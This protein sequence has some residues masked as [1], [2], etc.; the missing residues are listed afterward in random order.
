MTS[1]EKLEINAALRF[2]IRMEVGSLAE[3][4]EVQA[5][6]VGVETVNPTLG[7]SV[8][9]A[10]IG[11][12]PLNGRNVLD[13]ALLQ[14]GVTPTS[15][16]SCGACTFSVAGSKGDSVTFLLDGGINNNLLDNSVVFNPNPDTIEEFRILTSNYTAE[17][18]RNSGGIVSTV[19]KSGTN[20]LHGS[21]FE[22][23]R[24][25]AFNANTYFN[26]EQGIDRPV[27][28]R[29]QFG[30]SLGGP[31]VIPKVINGKDR[32]FWFFGWQSQRQ[33]SMVQN[34][35]VA[36][37]T[38]SELA[39]N[40]SQ[41]NSDRTGPDPNVVDFLQRNPYYQPN[42]GLAAQGII[43]PSRISSVL[44]NYIKAG[45]IPTSPTGILF[46]QGSETRNYNEYLGKTRYS[47][48]AER[49]HFYPAG[50]PRPSD[51]QSL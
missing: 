5:E 38:P 1:P 36:T 39:G 37:Y 2:D 46:P 28:K 27:L 51:D 25:D 33:T 18:G 48:L 43:D 13:L 42:S 19:V 21:L 17:Y 26:N 50:L 31:L 16:R 3:V 40:F 15:D 12:L 35:A 32:V 9:T 47:R 29:N 11:N 8:T 20:T 49:P 30:G 34:P 44:Q 4:V 6:A 23:L 10:A 24:N 41:S 7:Q 22:Y 14:P 45:L